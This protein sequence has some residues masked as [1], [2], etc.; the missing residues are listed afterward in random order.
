[1][2]THKKIIVHDA[3]YGYRAW[4]FSSVVLLILDL[5]RPDL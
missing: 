2:F 3:I 5:V 4:V 1:M